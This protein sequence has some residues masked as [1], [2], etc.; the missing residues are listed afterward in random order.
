[1]NI[2]S[3]LAA[4]ALSAAVIATP[5]AATLQTINIPGTWTAFNPASSDY[6]AADVLSLSVTYNDEIRIQDN[7][8]DV[9]FL[10]GP[11]VAMSM[12]IGTESWGLADFNIA[13]IIPAAAG[14]LPAPILVIS[15]TDGTFLAF[16]GLNANGTAVVS[17]LFTPGIFVVALKGLNLNDGG[18]DLDESRFGA[19]GTFVVPASPVGPVPGVPEPSTWAMLM[20]GF[21]LVGA[22]VRR[23]QALATA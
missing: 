19:F 10:T 18:N 17:G 2:K 23:R 4:I 11:G 1:M 13:A 7:G 8:V 3:M 14:F 5:A 9:F 12:T 16:G 6:Q 20:A 15:P 22:A 21:G